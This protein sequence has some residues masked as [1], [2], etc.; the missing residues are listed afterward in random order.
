[1]KINKRTAICFGIFFVLFLM[2]VGNAAAAPLTITETRI[3]TSGSASNPAIYEDKIVWQDTRNGGNDVYIY[4]VSTEKETGITTSGSASNPAIYGNLIVYEK[5]GMPYPDEP[6]NISS[7]IYMYD[8]S[9]QQEAQITTSGRAFNPDIYGNKIVWDGGGIYL[10][11][12]STKNVTTIAEDWYDGDEFASSG[13]YNSNPVIY[14]NWI[15]YNGNE[16]DD[17]F[18]GYTIYLYDLSTKNETWIA[19]SGN[20][21][22]SFPDIYN[23]EIVYSTVG[24][25]ESGES[26]EYV[27]MYHISTQKETKITTSGSATGPSIYDNRIVWRDWRNGWDHIELYMFDLSTNTETQIT[28]SGSVSNPR[29]YGD[30]IVWVDGNDIYMATLSYPT[31]PVADFSANITSG[32]APLSVQFNDGSENATGWAWNFGDGATSTQQNPTYTYLFAGNYTV[33]LTVSNSYGTDSKLAT[34]NVSAQ[35]VLPVFPGYTNPPT[36]LDQNGLYEDVNGNGILDFDDVV[37]YYDN[38]DWIEENAPL[39]LFDYNSNG[40]IDF[41]DVVKLYDML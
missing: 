12:I 21:G 13:R 41:D 5:H 27:Y 16:Y 26:G 35:P 38:M 17:I 1:M 4:D 2:T 32:Y 20:E 24:Y 18:N 19:Y 6:W 31:S 7:D 33:N 37:A 29:I 23:D 28:T 39:D 15:V 30:R 25:G 22:F 8:I 14:G 40:L 10:Y 9:T 36:D 11:D 3:T 34:I